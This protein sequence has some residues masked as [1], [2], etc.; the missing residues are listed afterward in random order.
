M[1]TMHP[2]LLIGP[3]DWDAR[4]HAA[5]RNLPRASRRCGQSGRRPAAR[6]SMVTAAEHAAL[7]YL[8]NF[9]P[10][11]EP[12]IALIPRAGRAEADGRRR[13]QHDS[14]GSAADLGHRPGVAASDG[15]DDSAWLDAIGGPC[16]T[17]ECDNM[18]T[19]MHG[20]LDQALAG[21]SIEDGTEPLH[22]RMRRKSARE[23]ACI[24]AACATLRAAVA[25]AQAAQ[26]SGAGVTAVLLAAEHAAIRS[27]A[28]DVRTL[29]SLDGGRTLRPFEATSRADGRTAAALHR[30]TTIR[31]LGRRPR[32]A[33]AADRE[34]D[35]RPRGPARVHSVCCPVAPMLPSPVQAN[36]IGL[37]LDEG[38]AVTLEPG[39]VYSLRIAGAPAIASALVAVRDDTVETLWDGT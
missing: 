9:T 1:L 32:L 39:S 38:P 22:A 13:R 19:R 14:G 34:C 7:A 8:T 36:G 2:T 10:K 16:I 3:A 26:R 6:S 33:R 24:H 4:A 25:A 20:E 27:G 17:C 23:L 11:L 18:P 30:R 35:A 21:R 12:A 29:F 5:R 37:A 28:Q 31:L 15:Q